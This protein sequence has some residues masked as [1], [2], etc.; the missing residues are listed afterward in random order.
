MRRREDRSEVR[1]L[2]L[3]LLLWLLLGEWRYCTRPR[4]MAWWRMEGVRRRGGGGPLSGM[5]VLTWVRARRTGSGRRSMRW[6][7]MDRE[8]S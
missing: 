2:L 8:P 4:V 6:L 1:V 3:L 7:A 5:K